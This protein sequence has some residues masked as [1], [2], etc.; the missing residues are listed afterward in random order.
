[1]QSPASRVKGSWGEGGCWETI[2]CRNPGNLSWH[3]GSIDCTWFTTRQLPLCL[4]TC[5]VAVVVLISGVAV[6]IG[7]PLTD[8]DHNCNSTDLVYEWNPQVFGLNCFHMTTLTFVVCFCA[9]SW[10]HIRNRF[11]MESHLLDRGP[12]LGFLAFFSFILVLGVKLPFHWLIYVFL[13]SLRIQTCSFYLLK[14]Q[15]FFPRV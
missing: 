6:L 9:E 7:P 14:M 2:A 1:M 3:Y 15:I 10:G 12:L 5:H 13:P 11:H 8:C 4:R